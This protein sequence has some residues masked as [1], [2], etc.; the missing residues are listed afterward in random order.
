MIHLLIHKSII[1]RWLALLK[2]TTGD[3]SAVHVKTNQKLF[4]IADVVHITIEC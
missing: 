4:S 2:L 3:R 1:H